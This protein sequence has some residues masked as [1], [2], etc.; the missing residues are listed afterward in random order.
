[1]AVVPR[2]AEAQHLP[3]AYGAPPQVGELGGGSCPL[4]PSSFGGSELESPGRIMGG[5][6]FLEAPSDR[7]DSSVS[8]LVP[9]SPAPARLMARDTTK[10]REPRVNPQVRLAQA[11]RFAEGALE[12]YNR[13][14]KVKFELVDAVPCIGIPEPHCIYTHINFTARSSKKGSQEQLFFAELY[15]CQ[16]RRE[17]F[18]ARS[19]KKGSR[20][21]P[22][23]AGRSLVQRG[24]VVT[25][26]EPLGPDSMVGRKLLERDDTK[27]VRK[28]ADFTYCYGCPQMISHPKGEM[29]IAGH[30]NIPHVYEGVR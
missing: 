26:C 1:M 14:K 22:S 28:N 30:C 24:F 3:Y 7:S 29:Y 11:K 23:N 4:S 27:V 6:Q 18:T 5:F 20:E 12:H 21:E 17:V 25:C 9:T 13:R 8:S 15:H 16:R 2:I 19:S 10:S